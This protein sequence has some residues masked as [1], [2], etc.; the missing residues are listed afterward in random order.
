ML[1]ESEEESRERTRA[2]KVRKSRENGRSPQKSQN[3]FGGFVG[4]ATRK[5]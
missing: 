1:G 3:F 4:E 5:K 2:K